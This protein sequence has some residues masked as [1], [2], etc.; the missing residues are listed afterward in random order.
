MTVHQALRRKG[1]TGNLEDT[2]QCLHTIC[3]TGVAQRRR[4]TGRGSR[5][6]SRVACS[7]RAKTLHRLQPQLHWA[8]QPAVRLATR[9]LNQ[10][11]L[12]VVWAKGIS[13]GDSAGD[14]QERAGQLVPRAPGEDALGRP[15]AGPRSPLEVHLRREMTHAAAC[16]PRRVAHTFGLRSRV[17]PYTC[18]DSVLLVQPH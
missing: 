16:P 6:Q 17:Q 9:P 15:C 1:S 18:Q 14:R 11:R 3:C 4:R 2:D 7:T 12:M 8:G 13:K 10:A 5:F